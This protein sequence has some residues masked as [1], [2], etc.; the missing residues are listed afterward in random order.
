MNWLL[1]HQTFNSILHDRTY[2][3]T[4]IEVQKIILRPSMQEIAKPKTILDV[5]LRL[6]KISVAASELLIFRRLE[7]SKT[8]FLDF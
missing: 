1:Q 4:N 8:M 7:A 2:V 3:L 6:S 5:Q